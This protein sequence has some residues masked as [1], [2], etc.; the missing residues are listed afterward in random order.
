MSQPGQKPAASPR[1]RR[2]A[3]ARQ[4]QEVSGAPAGTTGLGAR[5]TRAPEPRDTFSGRSLSGLP[6]VRPLPGR[7]RARGSVTASGQVAGG[8]S[9]F[10]GWGQVRWAWRELNRGCPHREKLDDERW[11][12]ADGDERGGKSSLETPLVG[13]VG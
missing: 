13:G 4:T 7:R 3:A 8:G 6:P 1:P 12:N 11:V 5:R 10:P 9:L 2:A